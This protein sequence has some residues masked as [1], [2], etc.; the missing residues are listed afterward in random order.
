MKLQM[1]LIINFFHNI[2]I[3]TKYKITV[4]VVGCRYVFLLEF[5]FVSKIFLEGKM[6]FFYTKTTQTLFKGC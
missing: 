6:V 2:K 1:R 4:A 5:R 3:R